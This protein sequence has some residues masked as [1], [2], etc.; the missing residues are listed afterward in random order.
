MMN[1]FTNAARHALVDYDMT[2]TDLATE[3]GM[4]R[5]Y[6][7]RVIS[8]ALYSRPAIEAIADYLEIS[9]DGWDE[10]IAP[11]HH[12]PMDEREREA[13]AL[14]QKAMAALIGLMVEQQQEDYDDNAEP[15]E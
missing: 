9:T 11:K 12:I 15:D 2:V 5:S 1:R 7:S 10:K 3:L 14:S 6:I 13:E 8:G 4:S